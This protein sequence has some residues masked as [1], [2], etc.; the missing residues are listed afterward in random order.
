MKSRSLNVT[1]FVLFAALVWLGIANDRL[2]EAERNPKPVNPLGDGSAFLL[3]DDKGEIDVMLLSNPADMI[4]EFLIDGYDKVDDFGLV[5]YSLD[6][7]FARFGNTRT[8]L[9]LMDFDDTP[10]PVYA[11]RV[12]DGVARAYV[13]PYLKGFSDSGQP[14]RLSEVV[15]S[16]KKELA[17]SG[18][19]EADFE[20]SW[21]FEPISQVELAQLQASKAQ[22]AAAEAA[23][24]ELEK[25]RKDIEAQRRKLNQ[26]EARL[27]AEAKA[28]E[29]RRKAT[30]TLPKP[31]HPDDREPTEAE[32]TRAMRR[33]VSGALL[34]PTI[35]KLGR[36]RKMAPFDY[37]CR[38]QY[39]SVNWGNY[40]KED[41]VWYFQIANA[42]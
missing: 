33:T 26:E 10:A 24:A 30:T 8:Y 4:F 12:R 15:R 36:C 39:L 16:V 25:Q 41:G 20:S 2:R 14:F 29:A 5:F 3:H 1:L 28:R 13:T 9:M 6:G 7:L 31:V 18:F 22:V 40:W 38:Y 37:Q 42:P 32:M 23:Q 34:K 17:E 19:D 21:R 27:R 35:T 11:F